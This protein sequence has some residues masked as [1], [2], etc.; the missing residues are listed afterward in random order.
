ML[1][2][3][4]SG[5]VGGEGGN[6][7]VYPANVGIIRSPVRAIA[8][9]DRRALFLKNALGWPAWFRGSPL[10]ARRQPI[11]T[12]AIGKGLRVFRLGEAEHH[13]VAVIVAQRV[14]ERRRR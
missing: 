5:S 14:R 7:L 3:G 4:A 6:I 1:E 10:A 11:P 12:E 8:L 9:P 2:T 13:K